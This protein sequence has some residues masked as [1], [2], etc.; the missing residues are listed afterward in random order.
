MIAMET[1]SE[2]LSLSTVD[3]VR[4]LMSSSKN[5]Y[6]WN[7]NCDLVKSANKGGY[8][9]FWFSEIVMSGLAQRVASGWNN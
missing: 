9:S 6:E 8:P 1:V 4:N 7:A 5:K 2:G 3:G